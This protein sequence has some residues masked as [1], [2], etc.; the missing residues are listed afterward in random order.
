MEVRKIPHC[1]SSSQKQK[2]A[3]CPKPP[4]RGVGVIVGVLVEVGITVGVFVG[5]LVEV[6]TD[7]GLCVEVGE[8]GAV[9]VAIG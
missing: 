2:W 6:L 9:A 3:I 1:I 4:P 7:V 8:A 5:V